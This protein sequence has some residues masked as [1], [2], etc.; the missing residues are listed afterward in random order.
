M[1]F[2]MLYYFETAESSSH[3]TQYTNR[4][5]RLTSRIKICAL[6][7][8]QVDSLKSCSPIYITSDTVPKGD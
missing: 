3:T 6:N 1:P 7:Q 2:K 8:T 4:Y 5:R